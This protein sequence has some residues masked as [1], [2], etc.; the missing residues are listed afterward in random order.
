[1][2]EKL[3]NVIRIKPAKPG[4]IVRDPETKRPLPEDGK[5]VR[6]SSYWV[7]RKIAGE[8]VL[9]DGLNE[10]KPKKQKTFFK[11]TDQ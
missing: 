2:N 7:R 1:M 5:L 9:C 3:E 8:I 4:L 10:T 6:W 11:E